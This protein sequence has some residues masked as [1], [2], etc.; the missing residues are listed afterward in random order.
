MKII[1]NK[2]WDEMNQHLVE[3]QLELVSA[4]QDNDTYLFQ[5]KYLQDKIKKLETKPK[6]KATT[7]KKGRTTRA[8]KKQ[9]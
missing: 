4:R 2:K 5:V 1:S 7:T 9:D 8:T 6:K 3:L